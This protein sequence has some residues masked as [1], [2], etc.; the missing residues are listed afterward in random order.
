MAPCPLGLCFGVENQF[1]GAE[2]EIGFLDIVRSQ[3][4]LPASFNAGHQVPYFLA[5]AFWH[6]SAYIPSSL[7]RIQPPKIGGTDANY[8]MQ[9]VQLQRIPREV[10]GY[11]FR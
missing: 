7:S 4:R 11:N 1:L 3:Q 8:L 10:N 2:W 6:R 5:R 9:Y